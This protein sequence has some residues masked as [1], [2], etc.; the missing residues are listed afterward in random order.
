MK[1]KS[2]FQVNYTT[3]LD[4]FKLMMNNRPVNQSRVKK[5][6]QSMMNEGLLVIPILVNKKME[7]IDGQHR[8][9]AGE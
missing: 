1:P 4:M 6:Y 2:D 8:Y 3:N 5:I 7:I 9:Q